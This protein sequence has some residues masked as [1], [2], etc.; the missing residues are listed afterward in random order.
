M[1]GV[2]HLET[3]L[4]PDDQRPKQRPVS[5]PSSIPAR[6]MRAF[7]LPAANGLRPSCHPPRSEL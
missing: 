4:H 6:I 7:P 2:V 1:V 3:A 5:R